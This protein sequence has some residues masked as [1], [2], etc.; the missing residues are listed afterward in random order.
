MYYLTKIMLACIGSQD[1]KDM[2]ATRKLTNW[3]GAAGD[4]YTIG[5]VGI[6]Y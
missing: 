3:K 4:G 2:K 5:E 1:T 6:P